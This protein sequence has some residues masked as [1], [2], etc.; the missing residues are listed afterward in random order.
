MIWSLVVVASLASMLS[1]KLEKTTG[2]VSFL[3]LGYLSGTPIYELDPDSLVYQ[4]NYQLN[5]DYFES[6]Y[7]WLTHQFSPYMQYSEFRLIS[8]LAVFGLLFLIVLLLTPRVSTISFFYAVAMFPADKAQVRNCMAALFIFL[9]AYLLLRYGNKGVIPALA[10]IYIGSLFHSLALFFLVLPIMWLFKDFSEKYFNLLFVLCV[11]IGAF[12]ELFGAK[13]LVPILSR[14]VGLVGSRNNASENI[15]N[16]YSGGGQPI[17]HWLVFLTVTLLFVVGGKFFIGQQKSGNKL[18]YQMFL[19]TSLM[20]G[21]ALILMTLSIDYIRILRIVIFFY[22]LYLDYV[23][24]QRIGL[25]RLLVILQGIIVAAS[26][27]F[28]ELWAYGFSGA[29]IRAIFGF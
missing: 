17:L 16:L 15:L 7:N 24:T 19:C 11:S 27:L 20:W 8:C 14:F 9:G 28:V 3:L 23:A 22:F 4:L 12:S 1:R 29:Q 21:F 25:A 13:V 6:G 2:F 10:V 18:Y 5:T 26:M